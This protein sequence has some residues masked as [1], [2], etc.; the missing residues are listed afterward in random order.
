MSGCFW[1]RWPPRNSHHAQPCRSALS[2]MLPMLISSVLFLILSVIELIPDSNNSGDNLYTM[3]NTGP[4]NRNNV[5][6]FSSWGSSAV[7][8]AILNPIIN[9]WCVLQ[10][11]QLITQH[12]TTILG[13][14]TIKISHFCH[15]SKSSG[16]PQRLSRE[17][18][19]YLFLTEVAS[20]HTEE[21]LPE[22]RVGQ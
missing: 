13:I 14:Q 4:G 18:T 6:S 12:I 2:L 21:I 10:L 3:I 15:S 17:N 1:R 9:Q 19:P 20:S 5:S 8:R 11:H 7:S 22:H 16:G